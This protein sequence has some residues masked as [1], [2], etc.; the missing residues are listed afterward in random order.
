MG[1]LV[2]ARV[3]LIFFLVNSIMLYFGFRMRITLVTHRCFNYW[4]AA[5]ILHQGR[6]SFSCCPACKELLVHKELPGDRI[7]TADADWPRDI[8]HHMVLGW[9]IKLEELTGRAELLK[10]WLGINWQVVSS[11]I[12]HCLFCAF[13]LFLLSFASSPRP[14]FFSF[15]FNCPY[16]SPLVLALFF[17]MLSSISLWMAAWCWAAWWVKSQQSFWYP[18]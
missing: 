15:L 5:L 12:V 7:R 17:L 14:F 11:C 9:A 10:D 8:Q 6:F 13:F 3:E 16:L 2:W 1:I 18:T 4:W